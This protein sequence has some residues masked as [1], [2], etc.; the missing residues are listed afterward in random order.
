MVAS[1]NDGRRQLTGRT[2]YPLPIPPEADVMWH[3]MGAGSSQESLIVYDD[4][5]VTRGQGFTTWDITQP[6]VHTF[7][8]GGTDFRCEA[9][10]W[11]HDT[12][13]AAGFH[14]QYAG[15]TDYSDD[16]DYGL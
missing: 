4:G 15:A 3:K 2:L 16:T 11:L 8:Q 12:L 13:V 9:S 1:V 5:T 10:G 6:T 7:I 14:C